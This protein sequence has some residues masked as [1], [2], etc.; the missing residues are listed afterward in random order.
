MLAHPSCG[1]WC[2]YCG[3][4]SVKHP[5]FIFKVSMKLYFF[6]VSFTPKK[7]GLIIAATWLF[8]SA[9]ESLTLFPTTDIVDGYCLPFE[10]WP[11][12]LAYRIVPWI[13]NLPVEYLGPTVVMAFCYGRIYVKLKSKASHYLFSKLH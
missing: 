3:D 6:Q 10:I 2:F 11:S 5:K 8:A 12:W 1:L 9:Y 4:N 13:V 7:T